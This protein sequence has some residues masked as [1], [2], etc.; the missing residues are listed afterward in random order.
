MA[1]ISW[2]RMGTAIFPSPSHKIPGKDFDW[3]SLGHIFFPSTK[4]LC[5]GWCDDTD[6]FMSYALASKRLGSLG[7]TSSERTWWL[8][9]G[10]S[11]F[12]QRKEW[13]C[14]WVHWRVCISYIWQR[15]SFLFC[16]LKALMK[17]EGETP[18]Q[19]RQSADKTSLKTSA[20]Y[21]ERWVRQPGSQGTK[22]ERSHSQ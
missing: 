15:M 21:F 1:L 9:E 7:L 19:H 16:C 14:L 8:K 3:S 4:S 12:A 22:A 13:E 17:L 20:T 6:Q 5:P 10:K 11:S 18:H 2:Q